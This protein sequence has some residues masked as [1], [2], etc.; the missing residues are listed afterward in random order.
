MTLI[1][2][3]KQ[4]EKMT[5]CHKI[6]EIADRFRGKFLNRIA[7]IENEISE[8]LAILFPDGK[9]SQKTLEQK[10]NALFKIIKTDYPNYWNANKEHLEP[11]KDL[12]R[13]RNQ[14]A[15]SILDVSETALS[16]PLVQGVAFVGWNNGKPVTDSEF[17]EFLVKTTM[18]LGLSLIHI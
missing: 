17:D 16:R 2:I 8:I 1:K 11:L 12:I 5:A 4:A 6:H 13:F 9:F 15:H 7:V 10:R 3:Q 14:L 18:V